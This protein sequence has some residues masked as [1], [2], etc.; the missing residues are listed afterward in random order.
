M[1][2]QEQELLKWKA[3]RALKRKYRVSN[4]ASR[5]ELMYHLVMEHG[6]AGL[7]MIPW[8]TEEEL[9][10]FNNWLRQEL[11]KRDERAKNSG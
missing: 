6:T 10:I 7:T 11:G 5:L 2:R 4:K 1:E 3:E 9:R 8:A